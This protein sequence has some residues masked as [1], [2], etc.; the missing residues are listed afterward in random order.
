[1]RENEQMF[2]VDSQVERLHVARQISSKFCVF[3]LAPRI[4]KVDVEVHHN[5]V[6]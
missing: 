4:A 3:R 6:W 5:N 1:M 2:E